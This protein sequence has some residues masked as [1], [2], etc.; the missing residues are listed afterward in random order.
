M[1]SLSCTRGTDCSSAMAAELSAMVLGLPDFDTGT[2]N[3]RR[4][5]STCSH[6]A[7]V[8]SLRRPPVSNSSLM[9]WAAPRFSSSSIG[10][11]KPLRFVGSQKPLPVNPRSHAEACG[12]V[13]ACARHVPLS[14]KI[15]NIA[16][17]HE[18]AIAGPSSISLGPHVVDQPRYVLAG[19][20]VEGET[21]EGRQDVDAQESFVGGPAPLAGL[22]MG[23]VAVADELVER[24]DGPQFLA[25]RLRVGTKQGLGKRRAAQTSSLL[26][27]ENIGGAKLELTLPAINVEITLV[28]GL[29]TG[30][31]DFEQEP[32][33]AWVEE[34]NFRSPRGAGGPANK[35]GSEEVGWHGLAKTC[36]MSFEGYRMH[37]A[38]SRA[39]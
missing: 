27:R 15:E 32:F 19:N 2:S 1:C 21:T 14:C 4:C 5:Q 9:A 29:A 16:Q 23:Q 17:E 36:R 18:D 11:D 28:E 13:H 37:S 31:S 30:R 3:V 22:G 7:W 35:L 12:R 34:V 39:A 24:W 20:L 33:L 26:N 8:I 6:L 10:G 25:A 38:R